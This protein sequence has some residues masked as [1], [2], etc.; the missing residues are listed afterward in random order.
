MFSLIYDRPAEMRYNEEMAEAERAEFNR[1]E[2]RTLTCSQSFFRISEV[3]RERINAMLERPANIRLT[4]NT[5][6]LSTALEGLTCLLAYARLG[7][8]EYARTK[9]LRERIERIITDLKP[10]ARR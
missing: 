2:T 9:E 7:D 4:W 3:E 10:G 6:E 5:D 8:E 1:H